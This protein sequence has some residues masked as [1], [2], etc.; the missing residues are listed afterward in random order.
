MNMKA[1]WVDK[2]KTILDFMVKFFPAWW[3]IM[4]TFI[5]KKNIQI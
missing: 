4:N 3:Q 2:L 5:L 1:Y